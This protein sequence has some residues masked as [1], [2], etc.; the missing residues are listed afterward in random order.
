M[1]SP[2]VGGSGSARAIP[3]QP[4]NGVTITIPSP[5]TYASGVLLFVLACGSD[6]TDSG[7]LPTTG[8][9]AVT[10]TDTADD[11]SDSGGDGGPA[12][13]TGS[14]DA[15]GGDGYDPGIKLD[16]G[17]GET[18]GGPAEGGL[19]EG[20][21]KIDFLF[22][23]DNS[24]SM[25][26]EQDLLINSFPAFMDTIVDTLEIEDFHILATD[27]DGAGF[28]CLEICATSPG[29]NCNGAQCAGIP[30]EGTCEASLGGGR[31]R[32]IDGEECGLEGGATYIQRG[33]S[34]LADT[35]A[36]MAR[37]GG[38]EPM[39]QQIEA[40]AA[41]V[42]PGQVGPGGCNEGFLRDDAILV[43]TLISDEDDQRFG[44]DLNVEVQA[45]IDAKNGDAEAISML[46]IYDPTSDRLSTFIQAFP[47]HTIGSILE[48]DY[49]PFFLEA[50]NKIKDTCDGFVPPG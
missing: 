24:A 17:P 10:G 27:T 1:W 28:G 40:T 36:C 16:V 47:Y 29:S 4:G 45:I 46:G 50:V 11:D 18:G 44:A 23:T 13:T 8:G 48:P 21:T 39:E 32:G 35:F 49:S 38:G 19:D 14:G 6:R 22:V 25:A 42:S 15:T 9:G 3:P 34:N 43:V 2:L 12:G 7:E 30:P 5:I 26:D 31:T 20:C 33:Q 37:H 41:A